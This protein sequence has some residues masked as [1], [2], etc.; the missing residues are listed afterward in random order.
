M[1]K[2]VAC[3]VCHK[4]FEVKSE[5]CPH[6]NSKVLRK[7]QRVSNVPT[8]KRAIA[9]WLAILVG[10]VGMHKFYLGYNKQ[11]SVVLVISLIAAVFGSSVIGQGVFCF[12]AFIGI[13]EGVSYLRCSDKE[14]VYTY[15]KNQ[16]YWF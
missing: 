9:G 14:F 7:V 11:G 6:C 8:K 3:P 13:L 1:V 12:M 4:I 10:S 16:K 15:V 5:F 2:S